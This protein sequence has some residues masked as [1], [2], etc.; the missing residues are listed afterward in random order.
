[1][2]AARHFD[3]M[4]TV[5]PVSISDGL[6]DSDARRSSPSC[7]TSSKARCASTAGR[8]RPTR[9]MPRTTARSRSGSWCPR[10]VDDVVATVGA[11]HRHGIPITSRGGGT[12]LAGQSTNVAVI[13]DFSKYLNR[14]VRID[15]EA[16]TA[17]VEPGCTL[18]D[19][20]RPPRPTD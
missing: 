14:V 8:A 17:V 19:L 13:I 7:A 5:T 2:T 1:M 12:S 9:P 18:D 20:R 3:G 15:P 6:D 10:S 11:C 16:R 4:D